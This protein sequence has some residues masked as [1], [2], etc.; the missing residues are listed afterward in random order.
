MGIADRGCSALP[1]PALRV[2]P[3]SAGA[4]EIMAGKCSEKNKVAPMP[5]IIIIIKERDYRNPEK[6]PLPRRLLFMLI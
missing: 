4:G 6:L 1:C 5:E 2:H 3:I